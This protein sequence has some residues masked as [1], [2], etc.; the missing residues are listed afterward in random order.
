MSFLK[1]LFFKLLLLSNNQ[2]TDCLPA[3]SNF[4]VNQYLGTWYEIARYD[5]WFE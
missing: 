2:S 1:M 5:H 3:I 4:N